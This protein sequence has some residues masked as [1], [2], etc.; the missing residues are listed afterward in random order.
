MRRDNGPIDCRPEVRPKGDKDHYGDQ[1]P[2]PTRHNSLI[3]FLRA[4][5][6]KPELYVLFG[7]RVFF[8][9]SF[10]ESMTLRSPHYGGRRQ[11]TDADAH[12]QTRP[13]KLRDR[14]NRSRRNGFL[15]RMFRLFAAAFSALLVRFPASAADPTSALSRITAASIDAAA[16][17]SAND[18]D[19][20]LIAKAE[21][22]LDRNRFSP[23]L[24]TQLPQGSPRLS[25]GPWARALR[26]PRRRRMECAGVHRFG[27]KVEELRDF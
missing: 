18:K 22:L 11:A 5:P 7:S 9:L 16:P 1:R 15:K 25:G 20:S 3:E 4:F 24:S 12:R 17:T 8:R 10:G 6:I 21:T 26:D 19:P 2:K 23:G 27:P 14:W 13:G